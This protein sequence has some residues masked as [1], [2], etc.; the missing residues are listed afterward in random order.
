M[1]PSRQ[2]DRA[3]RKRLITLYL[4]ER[5]RHGLIPDPGP[6]EA[7]EVLYREFWTAQ[8]RQSRLNA[9][10]EAEW[11]KKRDA[12][13]APP[14]P[15]T[16]PQAWS[17]GIPTSPPRPL[18]GALCAAGGLVLLLLLLCGVGALAMGTR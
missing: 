15:P 1:R 11:R 7:D 13:N 17:P 4:A 3:V 2:T 5:P 14:A 6:T 12:L 9:A 16:S 10:R 8:S 18:L